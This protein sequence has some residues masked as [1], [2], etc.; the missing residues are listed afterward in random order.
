M[1]VGP[2]DGLLQRGAGLVAE[3]RQAPAEDPTSAG[4]ASPSRSLGGTHPGR[5]SLVW[6]VETP[7]GSGH[8]SVRS[9]DREEGST[10][11]RAQDGPR[12]QRRSPKGNGKPG[13][14]TS[15]SAGHPA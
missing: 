9:A 1:I 5:I 8:V 10:P 15:I 13:Q 12:S 11:Q 6:N 2:A 4:R 7:L 14:M 3:K